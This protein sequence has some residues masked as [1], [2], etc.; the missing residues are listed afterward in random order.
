MHPNLKKNHLS[1]HHH[2][3]RQELQIHLHTSTHIYTHTHTRARTH[4]HTCTLTHII[5]RNIWMITWQGNHDN[6]AD[7]GRGTHRHT[8][9]NSQAQRC[10]FYSFWWVISLNLASN[11]GPHH[12]DL[13]DLREEGLGKLPAILE[14]V[15]LMDRFDRSFHR[16]SLW[17]SLVCPA[18][19]W[20]VLTSLVYNL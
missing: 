6:F 17:H 15:R 19:R 9:Y 13:L 16:F 14:I 18:T 2:H 20:V 12:F 3:K 8:G 11:L 1:V 10:N 5:I 4:A 7:R